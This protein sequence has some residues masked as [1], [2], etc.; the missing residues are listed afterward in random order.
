MTEEGWANR[1]KDMWLGDE[2][3]CGQGC[4]SAVTG[5]PFPFLGG[6]LGSERQYRNSDDYG[7]EPALPYSDS[8]TQKHLVI[9]LPPNNDVISH[10]NV[11]LW[12]LPQPFD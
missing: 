3:H 2:D 1:F 8:K 6:T 11:S 4:M 5:E 7:G 10:H 9:S 12:T